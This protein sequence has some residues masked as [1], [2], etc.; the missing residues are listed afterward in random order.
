MVE[1]KFPLDEH[2]EKVTSCLTAS[3]AVSLTSD[4][5]GVVEDREADAVLDENGEILHFHHWY[6]ERESND[7]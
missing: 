6:P 2:R 7:A 1:G 3:V 5:L 4:L